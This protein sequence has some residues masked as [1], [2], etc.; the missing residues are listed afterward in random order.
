M[1]HITITLLLVV[2][3]ILAFSQTSVKVG[4]NNLL[5]KIEKP[6]VEIPTPY[7][8]EVKGTEY[9][10]FKTDKGK[11]FITLF[12]EKTQKKYRRYLKLVD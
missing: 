12:S 9:P 5:V 10:V 11:Y 7:K 6:K 2:S 4:E 3:S 1:K 8:F